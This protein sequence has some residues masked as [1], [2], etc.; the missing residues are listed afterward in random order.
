MKMAETEETSAELPE[1]FTPRIYVTFDMPTDAQGQRSEGESITFGP[2]LIAALR[3]DD[4]WVIEGGLEEGGVLAKHHA[5]FRVAVKTSPGHGRAGIAS[6]IRS[7][8]EG[9]NRTGMLETWVMAGAAGVPPGRILSDPGTIG[10]I[11][12][13]PP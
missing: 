12:P 13:C 9:D 7:R 1:I 2:Y 4:L 10:G 3:D 11:S 8:V 6:G 5:L